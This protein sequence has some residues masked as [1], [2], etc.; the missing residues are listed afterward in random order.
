[1]ISKYKLQLSFKPLL[2]DGVQTSAKYKKNNNYT[3]FL[4][5]KMRRQHAKGVLNIN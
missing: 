3:K 4:Q 1:M 2:V 5:P